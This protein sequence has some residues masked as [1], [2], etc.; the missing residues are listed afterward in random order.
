M[1]A[2]ISIVLALFIT[3]AAA[4]YQRVSGPTYPKKITT[5]LNGHQYKFKLLRSHESSSDCEIEIPV[6]GNPVSAKIFYKRFP[7][8][9]PWDTIQMTRNGD[10]LVAALPVQPPA[11]K[12]Q[13][14]VELTENNETKKLD[15]DVALIRYKGD[16]PAWALIPHIIFIFL[17][18]FISNLAG[19]QAIFRINRMR[20]Y[21]LLAVICLFFG[22]FIFGPIVQKFAF[23]EFWTGVPF[24]WDL[25]DNKALV[26]IIA[27]LVALILN[28]RKARP[29]WIIIA[30]LVTIAAFCI[31]HSLFGSELNYASGTVTTG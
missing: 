9:D 4:Y 3:L 6:N 13:Y 21:T 20:L 10:N 31:P 8:N 7:T 24:G 18:M 29:V 5:Q 28:A 16:V 17:A 19:F 15:N 23:G 11:G 2:I 25:T 26:A 12:L 27:W 30:A 14:Y 22:G 1:K